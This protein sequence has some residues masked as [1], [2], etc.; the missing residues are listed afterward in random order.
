MKTP[1]LLVPAAFLL[2][3]ADAAQNRKPDRDLIKGTWSLVSV[4][5]KSEK[6]PEEKIKGTKLVFGEI[7]QSGSIW[8]VLKIPGEK[9]LSGWSEIDPSKDPKEIG[10]FHI[11]INIIN[12][13]GA[14]CEG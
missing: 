12:R 8:T 11:G 10:L 3:A 9:E 4:E 13:G 7:S 2:I 5:P 6:D 1:V 14:I